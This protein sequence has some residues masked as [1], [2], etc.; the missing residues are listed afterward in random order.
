MN[1]KKALKNLPPEFKG[2]F[3]EDENGI[4]KLAPWI[5]GANFMNMKKQLKN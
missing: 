2:Q 1:M 5:Q 3:Y 4:E